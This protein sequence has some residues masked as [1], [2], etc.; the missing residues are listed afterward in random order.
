MI[1]KRKIKPKRKMNKNY[2]VSFIGSSI[3]FTAGSCLAGGLNLLCM[4]YNIVAKN[5]NLTKDS[6]VQ[7]SA[8]SIIGGGLTSFGI[9][10]LVP[11]SI[12]N[13]WY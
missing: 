6:V 10:Y 13:L 5:K 4:Y 2:N 3:A 7:L 8:L 9:Y 1:S 11:N 12:R